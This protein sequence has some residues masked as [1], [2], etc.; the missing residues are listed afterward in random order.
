MNAHGEISNKELDT[1]LDAV[2]TKV[3]KL[4]SK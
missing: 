2:E 3:E 1:R 4:E